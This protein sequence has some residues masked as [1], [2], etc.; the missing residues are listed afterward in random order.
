MTQTYNGMTQTYKRKSARTWA[1]TPLLASVVLTGAVLTACSDGSSQ[2]A[3]GDGKG[4]GNV[5]GEKP[6]PTSPE[7]RGLA[8]A[9]CM[10]ENGVD[11]FP[12]PEQGGGGIRIGP[13]SGVDPESSQF[14]E[15]QEACKELSPQ[16]EGG[17]NGGKPL[18]SAKV[19]EWARC[20]RE[21]GV[22][23]FPDPEIDGGAM[24]IDMS[25]VGMQGDDPKFQQAMEACQD[26]RPAGGVMMKGGGG[27]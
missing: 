16:G 21:N 1:V 15:A 3:G 8:Y 5:A 22:P 10:R 6:A 19:A 12:D 27:R 11:K 13:G 4:G 14:K 26:K 9:K 7:D 23:K 18:D 25:A 20:M 24:V 2:A 17:P